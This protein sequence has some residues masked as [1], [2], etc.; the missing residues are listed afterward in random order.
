MGGEAWGGRSSPV[1]EEHAG[2][3]GD[4]AERNP[5]SLGALGWCGLG[6]KE[7]EE[8]GYKREVVARPL[9][10]AAARIQEEESTGHRRASS[11]AWGRR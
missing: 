7:E 9:L 2:G 10:L 3:R 8:E 6:Q 5:S 4:A 1:E 11:H